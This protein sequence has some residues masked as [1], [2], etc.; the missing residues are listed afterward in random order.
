MEYYS[1]VKKNEAVPMRAT[2]MHPEIVTLSKIRQKGED[3]MIALAC[4]T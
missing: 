3:H 1:A 4:E 2:W